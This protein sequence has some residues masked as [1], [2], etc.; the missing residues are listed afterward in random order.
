MVVRTRRA[1]RGA[2]VVVVGDDVDVVV[3]GVVVSVDS[4]VQAARTSEMAT[5][6][7]VRMRDTAV[8]TLSAENGGG[9]GQRSK[10]KPSS[11]QPSMPPIIFFTGL[12]SRARRSAALSAPLQ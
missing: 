4:A 12:P 1:S 11:R 2:A 7:V 10:E 3:D 8:A 6:A 5:A 9:D